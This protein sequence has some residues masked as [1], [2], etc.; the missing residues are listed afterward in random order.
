MRSCPA[1]AC[2]S[3]AAAGCYWQAGGLEEKTYDHFT[4]LANP[5][6]LA[7]HDLDVLQTA[8]DL[9]LDL[10]SGPHG[11]LGSLLD[12]ERVVLE[13]GLA[14]GGREVDRHGRP[15]GSLHGQG[16]DDADA[17]IA[18]IREVPA[19]TAEAER[20]LVSLEGLIAGV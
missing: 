18:L 17:R 1:F 7:L 11:E 15:A 16:E 20:L 19:A 2:Q 4:V 10:E 14:T 5:D 9:V 12:L 3:G 13:G 8:E 6:S